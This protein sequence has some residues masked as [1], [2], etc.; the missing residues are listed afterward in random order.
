MIGF[1]A[2][3]RFSLCAAL[4][5]VAINGRAYAQPSADL[6]V[7]PG[8]RYLT[9]RGEPVALAGD[10]GTQ[11]VMQNANLDYRRWI[12]DCASAGLN[13][14]HIWS[15]VAPRQLL[16]GSDVEDR[17]GYVYP[18][19]MGYDPHVAGGDTGQ[20]RREWLGHASRFFNEAVDDLI[21]LIPHG[22]AGLAPSKTG[23]TKSDGLYG[24]N[25]LYGRKEKR[26]TASIVSIPSISSIAEPLLSVLSAL[27]LKGDQGGCSSRPASNLERH[28]FNLS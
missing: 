11:C 25:G 16:D 7:T 14:V 4:A 15:F 6:S 13:C 28:G 9:F 2:R 23:L 10:S 5:L 1:P 20:V 24:R 12:D 22:P 18:G 3:A 21:G 8:G 26:N 27:S 19:I 17:Y